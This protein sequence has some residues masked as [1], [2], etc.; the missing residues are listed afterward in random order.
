M[1]DDRPCSVRGVGFGKGLPLSR[2]KGSGYYP[3]LPK[4][5]WFY[6]CRI[7]HFG[8]FWHPVK[9]SV[10]IN[11]IIKLSLCVLTWMFFVPSLYCQTANTLTAARCQTT[12]TQSDHVLTLNS[13]NNVLTSEQRKQSLR[14]RLIQFLC[15]RMLCNGEIYDFN[16]REETSP[17][18]FIL[19]AFL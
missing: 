10:S 8:A 3:P 9:W 2:K 15:M 17:Q 13:V 4:K 6:R 11:S 7:P 18:R 14:T 16:L 19:T 1:V 12:P 5:F